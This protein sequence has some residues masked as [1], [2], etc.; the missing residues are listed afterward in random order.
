MTV[1]AFED[2]EG[3]RIALSQAGTLPNSVLYNNPAGA[4]Q[5]LGFAGSSILT[6]VGAIVPYAG[7]DL[8]T[9]S[10]WLFCGGQSV[11]TTTYADLFKVI[12]YTY[13]GSGSSFNVPDLRGR[14]A[15]GKDNMSGSS[16]NRLTSISGITGTT[17]GAAG[18]DQ[19]IQ[20]HTHT[21]SGTTSGQSADHTH[22]FNPR[23][24]AGWNSGAIQLI[25]NGGSQYWGLRS[26]NNTSDGGTVGSTYGV[27]TGHTHT[28]SG[29]TSNHNQ[30]SGGA[31]QNVQPT[32]VTNYIIKAVA[33]TAVGYV[34]TTLT[35][36]AGGDLTGSYPNPSLTTI[37]NVPVYNSNSTISFR[38]SNVERMGVDA[39]GRVT[40]PYQPICQLYNVTSRAGS[41]LI[42]WS[43]TY[44]NVGSMWN[45]ATRVTVPVAGN[46]LC[47]FNGM[48]DNYTGYI[49]VDLFK[50]GVRQGTRSYEYNSSGTMHKHITF[51]VIVPLAANDYIEWYP[52]GG[53][54]Y[55]DGAGYMYACVALFS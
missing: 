8:S 23:S 32:L 12:G 35:G 14:V 37:S 3:M 54:V 5:A 20:D 36:A 39:S 17:L 2:V 53:T 52:E 28:Y 34:G 40:K 48:S 7:S 44:T 45:G 31:S 19:R 25:I 21:F 16:A 50:N 41:T 22:S 47:T 27:S 24:A 26:N 4:R 33:D 30:T 15:A 29:T 51:S 38:T 42:S 10:G 46:Y 18:G 1:P 13:G 6:P 11:S 55:A 43:G 9:P 49:F